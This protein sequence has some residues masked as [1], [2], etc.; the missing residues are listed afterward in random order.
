M[1]IIVTCRLCGVEFET[2]RKSVLSGD[3]RR[4]PACRG[5]P[6]LSRPRRNGYGGM[7]R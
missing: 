4:C 6:R 3:W 5:K 7:K 2:D 1:K